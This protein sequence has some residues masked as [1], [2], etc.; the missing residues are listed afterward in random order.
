MVLRKTVH[1]RDEVRHERRPVT[2]FGLRLDGVRRGQ[3]CGLAAGELDSGPFLSLVTRP[4][5]D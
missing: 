5:V 2:G 4:S 3:A 1:P